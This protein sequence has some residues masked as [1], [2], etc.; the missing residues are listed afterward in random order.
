MSN[1]LFAVAGLARLNGVLTTR[2]AKDMN[3]TKVLEKNAF[4]DIRLIEL[5][6]QMIKID[7]M[8]F[9]L[10]HDAFKSADDQATILAR[11]EKLTPKV[12]NE[13]AAVET[14]TVADETANVV[15]DAVDTAPIS[16]AEAAAEVVA[17]TENT[18]NETVTVKTPYKRPSRSKAAI[19]AREAAKEDST[20]TVEG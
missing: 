18:V 12:K 7:A 15:E 5:P 16:A 11:I 14:P 9:I 1:K 2:V 20:E 17:D 3:R 4:T 6:N 13:N 19:A 10:D 8:R